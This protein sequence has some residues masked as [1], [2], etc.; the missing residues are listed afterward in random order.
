[1]GLCSTKDEQREPLNPNIKIY[2]TF[3]NPYLFDSRNTVVIRHHLF[4]NNIRV[5]GTKLMANAGDIGKPVQFDI[6]LLNNGTQCLIKSELTQQYIRMNGNYIDC[7]GNGDEL[8]IFNIEK[9]G[10]LVKLK[11]SQNGLY[12]AVKGTKVT[13]GN[14]GQESKLYCYT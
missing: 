10:H 4:G 5:N 6:E 11:S 1:M 7:N 2:D 8:C 12:I 14:G 13:T 3:N 9:D